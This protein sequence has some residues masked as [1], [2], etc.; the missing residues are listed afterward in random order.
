MEGELPLHSYVPF[1][2]A[3]GLTD[4]MLDQDIKLAKETERGEFTVL[5]LLCTKKLE[6]KRFECIKRVLRDV[7]DLL[8][9]PN[10]D[11]ELPIHRATLEG[12]LECVQYFLKI[13]P[14]LLYAEDKRG[15]IPLH[16]VRDLKLCKWM[17]S[18][19]EKLL[20]HETHYKIIPLQTLFNWD[21]PFE[22]IKW[23]I[24]Q[25]PDLIR[26][27]NDVGQDFLDLTKDYGDPELL[28]YLKQFKG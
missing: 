24:E 13:D 18:Q 19:D 28:E 11:G 8:T 10:K 12:D 17:V 5:H 7:P 22:V 16:F 27:K 21:A 15:Q 14:K 2:A 20:R 25:D 26:I 4:W 9:K 3:Q 1:W 23:I 6:G